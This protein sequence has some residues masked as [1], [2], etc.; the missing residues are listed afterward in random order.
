[1]SNP[2][3]IGLYSELNEDMYDRLRDF[4]LLDPTRSIDSVV[5]EALL[6]LLAQPVEAPNA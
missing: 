3:T 1:M 5:R 6:L 4:V 2:T